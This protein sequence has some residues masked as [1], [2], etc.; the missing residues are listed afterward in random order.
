MASRAARRQSQVAELKKELDDLRNAARQLMAG[1]SEYAREENW[2]DNLWIGANGSKG[3]TIARKFLGLEE[4][5]REELKS[6]TP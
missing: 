2:A 1:L 5:Q 6:S 4:E 3:P